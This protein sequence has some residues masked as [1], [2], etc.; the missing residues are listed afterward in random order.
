MG[1][2]VFVTDFINDALKPERETLGALADVLAL[3]AFSEEELHGRIEDADA[4]MVYHNLALTRRTLKRLK[5]C[6]LIVRCGVGFDNVDGPF[7]RSRGIA[8]ANVPDYGA[9]EVADTAIGMALSIARGISFLNSRLRGKQG[10]WMY[11]QAAPLHRL[12]GRVFGIAGLGRI[13][14]AAAARAKALGMDAIFYDPLKPD[15]YDKALGI[16]RVESVEALFRSSFILSLHCPLTPA[17][18]HLVNA[19]T[20]QLL[21]KGAVLVNTSRGAVV[22]VA[23]IPDAIASGQLLG[24]GIDV[25]EDEP[26]REDN[27]LLA[28]WRNPEHPA[29]H[30]VLINPHAA[31]YCEEGLLEMRVKGATACRL[32]LLGEGVRNVVN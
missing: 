22:D 13:G 20:I 31:F 28:A 3:N 12:R 21:P 19:K 7:A 18:R 4:L 2:K 27:P 6:K 8:L 9:E 11:T 15:G 25:L 23:A 26:P 10:P 24:A 14:T 17:T 32:A 16:R 1:F 5:K 29:H 30:R